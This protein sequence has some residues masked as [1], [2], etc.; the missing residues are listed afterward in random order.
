MANTL[1]LYRFIA[2]LL[3]HYLWHVIQA[4]PDDSLYIPCRNGG[5]EPS[6]CSSP[7]G[8]TQVIAYGYYPTWSY[9]EHP[10]GIDLACTTTIFGDPID[11]D[12]KCCKLQY[13]LS[14][15]SGLSP[16]VNNMSCGEAVEHY[17]KQG[18]HS[19]THF[20]KFTLDETSLVTIS[21]CDTLYDTQ[22]YLRDYLGQRVPN[23]V[24]GCDGDDC[25]CPGWFN[26]NE[27]FVDVTLA[28]GDYYI[29]IKPYDQYAAAGVFHLSLSCTAAPAPI[30]PP[31]AAPITA[32]TAAPTDSTNAPTPL[33]TLSGP[34]TPSPTGSEKR[35]CGKTENWWCYD[36]DLYPSLT[37]ETNHTVFITN[38]DDNTQTVFVILATIYGNHCV[39]PSVLFSFEEI[40]FSHTEEYIALYDNDQ[41]LIAKC[42]GTRDSGCG[43]WI[44][45]LEPPQAL[46]VNKI[47]EGETY[48]I[49]VVE[50]P[51]IA[52]LCTAYH[53]YSI[54]AKVTMLCSADS[55]SPT[56]FPAAEPT[57]A[58]SA[59]PT[60]AP[61]N[62]P[63]LNPSTAPSTHPTYSPSD[64]P[65]SIPTLNPSTAPST[66]P[67]YSPSDSPSSI[68]T[69]NPS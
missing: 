56:A 23:S 46:G 1:Q 20:W 14:G 30:T 29:E 5:W 11:H 27:A 53:P 40:D 19:D 22:M 38:G 32:S 63:T 2:L 28:S 17:F 9:Y 62:I 51:E 13:D 61:S 31:T 44:D 36:I 58:P 34:T 54:N 48:S 65:S 7:S 37:K 15:E 33:P 8:I 43:H 42:N 10:G 12:K 47:N 66:H 21:N 24:V 39:K 3:V 6:S 67:T 69:L 60:S 55:A 50:S 52:A 25:N 59:S 64:S 68:P 49:Y 4:C 45:C 18:I 35:F 57:S 41:S 16:V 26:V